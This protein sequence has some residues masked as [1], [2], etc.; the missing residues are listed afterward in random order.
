MQKSGIQILGSPY[1]EFRRVSKLCRQQHVSIFV[2]FPAGF[3]IS[4][5]LILKV[6]EDFPARALASECLPSYRVDDELTSSLDAILNRFAESPGRAILL[7]HRRHCLRSFNHLTSFRRYLCQSLHN[8]R[9]TQVFSNSRANSLLASGALKNRRAQK[10]KQQY[11]YHGRP[12][13]LISQKR[14]FAL[15]TKDVIFQGVSLRVEALRRR[16]IHPTSP[17]H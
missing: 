15:F 4:L 9:E 17:T 13:S 10:N 8:E 6:E 1:P 12:R 7:N 3:Q 2:V 14:L 11:R 16:S 5:L